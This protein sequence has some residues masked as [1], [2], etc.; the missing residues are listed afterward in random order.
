MSQEKDPY[1]PTPAA[2]HLDYS[3]LWK[4]GGHANNERCVSLWIWES[5]AAAAPGSANQTG[6]FRLSILGSQTWTPWDRR[7][8]SSKP[9]TCATVMKA[10]TRVSQAPHLRQAATCRPRLSSCLS[11]EKWDSDFDSDESDEEDLKVQARGA[12]RVRGQGERQAA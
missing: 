1:H 2:Q 6:P 3:V 9:P 11:A 5:L 7:S 12:G 10:T 8:C 4:G